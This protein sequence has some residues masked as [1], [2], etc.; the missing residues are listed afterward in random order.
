MGCVSSKEEKYGA[1][2]SDGDDEPEEPRDYGVD[3]HYEVRAPQISTLGLCT[4][5]TWSR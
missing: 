3:E 5:C 1:R 2:D 4:A